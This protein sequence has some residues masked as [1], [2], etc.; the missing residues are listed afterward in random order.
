MSASVTTTTQPSP[1]VPPVGAAPPKPT[2]DQNDLTQLAV[3]ADRAAK[4]QET[5]VHLDILA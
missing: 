1:Y 5:G 3:Q 2:Q 4:A